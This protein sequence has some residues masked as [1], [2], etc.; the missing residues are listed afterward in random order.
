MESKSHCL[1]SFHPTELSRSLSLS[2]SLPSLPCCI[3]GTYEAV[4]VSDACESEAVW[5]KRLCDVLLIQ[6]LSSHY[7]SITPPPSQAGA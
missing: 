7:P 1:D 2:L 3:V 4:G 6:T 5:N